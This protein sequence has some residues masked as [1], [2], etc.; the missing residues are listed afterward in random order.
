MNTKSEFIA[1]PSL[2]TAL[3]KVLEQHG[4]LDAVTKAPEDGGFCG[5]CDLSKAPVELCDNCCAMVCLRAALD[6][7]EGIWRP[8]RTEAR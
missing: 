2:H 3:E 8:A 5:R 6:I 1:N 7:A 4:L